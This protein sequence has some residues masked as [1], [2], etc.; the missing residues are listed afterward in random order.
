MKLFEV[1]EIAGILAG[2]KLNK[3]TDKDVK[4]ALVLDFAALRKCAKAGSEDIEEIRNKFQSDWAAEIPVI[5]AIRQGGNEVVGYDEYLQAENDANE[6]IR[7]LLD[8]EQEVKLFG[9]KMDRFIQSCS[10]EITFEQVMML[11]D[12]GILE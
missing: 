1:K 12:C 2:M 11:Q 10:D 4:T 8:A 7:S 5:R 3:I 6:L 9:V